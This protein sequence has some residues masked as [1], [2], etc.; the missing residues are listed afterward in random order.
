MKNM[1]KRLNCFCN[2]LAKGKF[3]SSFFFISPVIK[4]LGNFAEV[5]KEIKRRKKKRTR[6]RRRRKRKIAVRT[7]RKVRWHFLN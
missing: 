5:K 7:K 3:I 1:R 4:Q 2:V 6:I